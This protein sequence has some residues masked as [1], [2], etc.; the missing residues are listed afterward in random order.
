MFLKKEKISKTWPLLAEKKLP[1]DDIDRLNHKG[2]TPVHVELTIP[3]AIAFHHMIGAE[4]KERRLKYLKYYWTDKVKDHPD[5]ILNTPFEPERSCAIANV[6][7]RGMKSSEVANTLFKDHGIWVVA[8]D[9]PGVKG[10]RIT[11]NVFTST[12]ELDIFVA[13]LLKLVS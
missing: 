6:G 7:I 4:R 11:P 9:R 2:T 13:S 5:I 8:I 1:V 3:D 10:C 12:G